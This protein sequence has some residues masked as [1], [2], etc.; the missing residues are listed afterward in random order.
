MQRIVTSTIA[1]LI[2]GSASISLAFAQQP[3][4]TCSA[5]SR[6]A[7]KIAARQPAVPVDEA[8]KQESINQIVTGLKGLFGD[9]AV[10][11]EKGGIKVRGSMINIDIGSIKV[12][13]PTRPA[14][15][16]AP[17]AWGQIHP[18]AATVRQ[19]R[20]AV[21]SPSNPNPTPLKSLFDAVETVMHSQPQP[22]AA[23]VEQAS[24]DPDPLSI[25]AAQVIPP[26]SEPAPFIMVPQAPE[27]QRHPAPPSDDMR[28][29]FADE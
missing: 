7:S 4:K 25:P 21:Q 6:P 1:L 16:P 26:A 24:N 9:L 19:V 10:K 5:P 28:N 14:D 23:V 18:S 22:V 12:K 17:E 13:P 29:E 2:A 11:Q 20:S 27:A 3:K 15:L 8:K